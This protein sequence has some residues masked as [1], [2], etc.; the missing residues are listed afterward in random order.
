MVTHGEIW[1]SIMPG[2]VIWL[3]IS[4]GK[5]GIVCDGV[6]WVDLYDKVALLYDTAQHGVVCGRRRRSYP[7]TSSPP[8]SRLCSVRSILEW[9][10]LDLQ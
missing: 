9:C 7:V 6:L 3:N 4:P 1:S 10:A 2:I 8:C 5:P